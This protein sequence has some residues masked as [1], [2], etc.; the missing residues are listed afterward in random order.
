MPGHLPAGN[1]S[2][3]IVAAGQ[4]AAPST[5]SHLLVTTSILSEIWV[6]STLAPVAPGSEAELCTIAF[7]LFFL[8]D[9]APGRRIN[10]L[11]FL[12]VI[13]WIFFLAIPVTSRNARFQ[14][15]ST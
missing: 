15:S 14:A 7:G 12:H 11:L 13:W 8:L 9:T 3:S 10:L 2:T 1:S 6:H 4:R 5:V